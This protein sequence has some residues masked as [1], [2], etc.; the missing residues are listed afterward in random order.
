MEHR[1]DEPGIELDRIDIDQVFVFNDTS[2]TGGTLPVVPEC[3]G[4]SRFDADSLIGVNSIR[5]NEAATR[6]LY[7]MVMDAVGVYR[8]DYSQAVEEFMAEKS[9][10]TPV[11]QFIHEKG[12][13]M[14]EAKLNHANAT[15]FAKQIQYNLEKSLETSD[16]TSQTRTSAQ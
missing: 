11:E 1:T 5:L 8:A 3:F 7:T 6:K 4:G 9:H 2:E 16:I 15:G 12:V 14:A 13:V 10:T